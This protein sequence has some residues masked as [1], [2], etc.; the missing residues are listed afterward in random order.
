MGLVRALL[1]EAVLLKV[2]HGEKRP[3]GTAWQKLTR[4]DMTPSYLADLE[5]HNVGVLLGPESGNLNTI[6]I[7]VDEFVEPF[8]DLNPR[9]RDTLRSKRVRGCNVWVRIRGAYPKLTKITTTGGENWGEWRS[10]GGQTVIL[11]EVMDASKGET[12]PTAYRI[13]NPVSPVEIIFDE[14]VWPENLKL[15]WKKEVQVT[16]PPAVPAGDDR[17]D[18]C[19]DDWIILPSG[20][21]SITECADKLFKKIGPT[22]TIFFRGGAVMELVPGDDGTLGLE[23]V[24]DTA[25]R[26]RIEQFG[27]VVAWRSGARGEQVLKPTNCP[28]ET[29]AALLATAEAREY[30]PHI[31]TVVN[32][33]VMIEGNNE[34]L[35]LPKG[36]HSEN[37]G[38]LVTEGIAP[39]EV[40]I[41]EAV[42][43]LRM[44]FSEFDFQTPG[45]LSRAL[46]HTI[47]PALKLGGFIKGFVPA[48]V[49]EADQS[50]S[51]KTFRQRL[52]CSIYAEQPRVIARREGGVGSVDESF[53]A[54]LITG[55][56]F[57]QFDNFRGKLDS[58]FIEAFM[59]ATGGFSARVPY[60]GEI[61]VDPSRFF[62]LLTSNGV[63]S[64]RDMANRSCIV[65]IRKRAGFA[66]QVFAEGDISDHV[67]ARQP[68]FLGCVFAVIREWVESGKQRT[69]VMDHD[70]RE[71]AQ[72]LDWIVQNIFRAAPL[73]EGHQQAQARISDPAL[74]F[75]R[76]VALEVRNAR[77]LENTL[78]ANVIV[79]ICDDAGIE[80]PGVKTGNAGEASRRVG[81]L[82]KR[83]FG[84]QDAVEVDDFT[85]TRT[86]HQQDRLDGGGTYWS[87]AYR[88]SQL[89]RI[90]A[91]AA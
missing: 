90:S 5:G 59:T 20:E 76:A 12:T 67:K 81:V 13:L 39:P 45:D 62:I 25:F 33:P 43:S 36:Y 51:G 70:F 63:E 88:F 34:L 69:R 80:I 4:T 56:P 1:P 82:M 3:L 73:L 53:S 68:Y 32:A 58:Q 26:S 40:P 8:L 23:V 2:A 46:A 17:A 52:I 65:R 87:R 16:T 64:T 22:K 24:N 47:T 27:H 72:T 55:H 29:A 84:Q 37:G 15:S 11:G 91:E 19:A 77:Q 79:D 89:P 21:V 35:I 9:L 18:A 7:D 49:A 83:A 30:L 60:H 48:D 14:I 6:D 10:T 74:N 75:L 42:E 41:G 31:A 44:I 28:K 86:N 61:Q 54:A 71:W 78:A 38:I 85:V 66:F 50:Q 57:I